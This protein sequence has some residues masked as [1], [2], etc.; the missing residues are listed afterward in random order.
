MHIYS[1]A[2]EIC[3]HLAINSLRRW[4]GPHFSSPRRP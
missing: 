1:Y 4:Q 2:Y 3:F